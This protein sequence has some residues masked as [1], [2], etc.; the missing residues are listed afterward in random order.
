M[1]F[2]RPIFILK[3]IYP[4]AIWRE[5]KNK[6]NIYLTFD[7]GPIPE[8]T[9][10][11]LD[12]LKEK[13][14]KATFFCVGENIKKHPEIFK[15][16]LDEGH[17][18]G[19]HTYNHL[20]GWNT[21]NKEYFDNIN[22]CQELTET[23]LFRPPYG[24]ARKSQMK[25]LAKDFKIVMWDVLTGDYDQEITPHECYKNCIDKTRNGSI[26]VFHDNIKAINNVKYALPKSIDYLIEQGYQFKTLVP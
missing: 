23:N 22:R 12:C 20:R 8:I 5:D 4:E 1:H 9:P 3:Y 16:L 6:N 10:W 19:N 11:I 24:R 13:N 14:V 25:E 18:V 7:D 17:V 26:I 21:E 15:R 2:V